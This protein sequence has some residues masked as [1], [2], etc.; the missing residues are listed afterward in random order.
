MSKIM[1]EMKARYGTPRKPPA[2]GGRTTARRPRAVSRPLAVEPRVRVAKPSA[3]P[4]GDRVP[5]RRRSLPGGLE[6]TTFEGVDVLRMAGAP[7]NYVA[8][9]SGRKAGTFEIY[10]REPRELVVWGIK[11]GDVLRQFGSLIRQDG[12]E[13][14]REARRRYRGHGTPK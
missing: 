9:P 5:S 13:A 3:T 10:R 7:T 11:P 6:W 4:P 2:A 8:C 1:D 14:E 12:L